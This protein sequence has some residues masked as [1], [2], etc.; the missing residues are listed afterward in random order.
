MGIPRRGVGIYLESFDIEG[1]DLVVGE[2][3]GI[4]ECVFYFI[5][6]LVWIWDREREGTDGDIGI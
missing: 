6:C 4:T 5:Y 1:G 3:E 2:S